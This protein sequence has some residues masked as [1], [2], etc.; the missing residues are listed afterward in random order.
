[1]LKQIYKIVKKFEKETG[2]P[3]QFMFTTEQNQPSLLIVRCVFY[4]NFKRYNYEKIVDGT[5]IGKIYYKE[6]LKEIKNDIITMYK[7]N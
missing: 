6:I 5:A 3:V 1:M 2:V 7:E 4:K